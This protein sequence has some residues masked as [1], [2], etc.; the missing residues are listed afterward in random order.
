MGIFVKTLC[1]LHSFF[2]HFSYK[3]GAI[4]VHSYSY[5][6]CCYFRLHQDSPGWIRARH[7]T[8]RVNYHFAVENHRCL[9]GKSTISMAMFNSKL[10]VYQ[11]VIPD[12]LE[13]TRVIY[14]FFLH[15]TDSPHFWGLHP[16]DPPASSM[17]QQL[18]MSS[19]SS[20]HRC[21]RHKKSS[22]G[23]FRRAA[24]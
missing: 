11:R 21:E 5:R 13:F 3:F 8:F 14:V 17:L 10:L 6:C 7:D 19:M 23:G 9:M 22:V 1:H 15:P 12:I 4:R 24:A 20:A 16:E 18:P 2:M